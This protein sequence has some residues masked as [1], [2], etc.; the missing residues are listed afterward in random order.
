[1]GKGARLPTLRSG[2]FGT[3]AHALRRGEI[4]LDDLKHCAVAFKVGFGGKVVLLPCAWQLTFN[5]IARRLFRAAHSQLSGT[6]LGR[7]LVHRL[8]NG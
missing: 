6:S 1:M 4:A 2:R 5:P 8:R 3:Y 7:A